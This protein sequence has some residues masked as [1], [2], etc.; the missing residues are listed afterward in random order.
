[1][2]DPHGDQAVDLRNNLAAES[3]TKVVYEYL[4]QFT[5]DP[6]VQDTLTFFMTRELAH[7]RQ[8]TA[9]LNELP[10]HPLRPWALPFIP[11]VAVHRE[12]RRAVVFDATG[13]PSRTRPVHPVSRVS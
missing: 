6:G 13:A 2:I 9:A 3:R 1:L 10:V 12:A 8:F 4:K 7:C 11:R 5:D